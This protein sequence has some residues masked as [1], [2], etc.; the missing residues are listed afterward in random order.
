MTL[1]AIDVSVLVPVG[2]EMAPVGFSLGP[3]ETS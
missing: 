1:L 2:P 3:V